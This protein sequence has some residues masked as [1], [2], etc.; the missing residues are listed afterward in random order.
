MK[1]LIK[2]FTFLFLFTLTV[3]SVSAINPKNRNQ[4]YTSKK[5]K[6]RMR[7]KAHR[8]NKNMCKRHS[9]IWYYAHNMQ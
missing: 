5:Y 1:T 4:Y 6:K 9:R 2:I 8:I 7:R 3:N